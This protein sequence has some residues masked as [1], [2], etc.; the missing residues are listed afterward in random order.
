MPIYEY[1]ALAKGGK[2]KTGILDADTAKSARDKLR[3]QGIHVVAISEIQGTRKKSFLPNFLAKKNVSELAMVTRQLATLMESGIPLRE[4]IGA[5]IDQVEDRYMQTAFRDIREKITSGKSFADALAQHPF[6][7]SNLYVNMIRAGETAGNLDVILHKLANYLQA[8]SRMRG[9]VSAALAYPLVMMFIG[10]AVVIFL[11]TFVIP[12]LKSVLMAQGKELPL[13]TFI[14]VQLS[15]FIINYWYLLLFGVIGIFV[16]FKLFL[17]TS[18]GKRQFDLAMISMPILGTLFKKQAVS[19]FAVTFST[20]LQSGI[21]A[22]DCLRILR[23]VVD[24]AIMAETIDDVAKT[25]IDGG[26]IATPLRKS[27]AFP[28][29]VGYMISVGE[30]AGRLE[31]ILTKIAEAYDEEV[32]VSTQKVTSLMEPIMIVLLSSVVGFIVLSIILPIMKMN[33]LG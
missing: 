15:S 31:E 13:P 33:Q 29:L 11:M 4:S 18:W 20:L 14:M 21:P 5:L 8:Q 1:K 2:T 30:K 7:F 27:K 12:K 17:K 23:E 6:Y 9:K 24:N 16:L 25:I 28:T 19:R 32:E 3:S 10:T 26:D 22:L